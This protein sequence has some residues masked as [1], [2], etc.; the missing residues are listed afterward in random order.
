MIC[1]NVPIARTGD[2]QYMPAELGLSIDSSTNAN[3]GANNINT[4][5]GTATSPITVTRSESDV[6]DPAALASF[7]GKPV[8]DGHPPENVTSTN[9]GAYEKGHIQNVRRGTGDNSNFLIADLHIKDAN[10]ISVIKNNLRRE[11]SCGYSY[12]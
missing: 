12:D 4:S 10:L 11:V 6:F 2:M 1:L 3:S 5:T 8:T 9:Y 7:E